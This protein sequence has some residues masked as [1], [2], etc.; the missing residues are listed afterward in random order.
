VGSANVTITF[1]HLDKAVYIEIERHSSLSVSWSILHHQ[2]ITSLVHKR[3]TGGYS[4]DQYSALL[5]ITA[6]TCFMLHLNS[7]HW[8]YAKVWLVHY[9]SSLNS[10]EDMCASDLRQQSLVSIPS[11]SK[12]PG[13]P[14]VDGQILND[15]RRTSPPSCIP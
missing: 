2:C 15:P 5:I 6:N 7:C 1:R 12:D 11:T 13:Y 8:L 14:Y 9:Q 3:S 4:P 10:C